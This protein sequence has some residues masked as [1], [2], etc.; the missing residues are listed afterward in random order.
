MK[1]TSSPPLSG[2]LYPLLQA[3]DEEYL[4]VD[5]QFGGID[6]RKIFT[7]AEASLPKLGFG[8][9][10]HLMNAMVP[11]LAGGKMSSSDP[12]SKIDFLDSP[13]EVKKKIKSAVAAPGVVE[14]NGLLAFIRAV[15]IPIAKLQS[16]LEKASSL[17]VTEDAPSGSLLTFV[18]KA[19][20]GGTLHFSDY[21]EIEDFYAAEKLHP[22]DLKVFIVESINALLAPVQEEFRTNPAFQEAERLAYPPPPAPEK[23]KKI[24]KTP[25]RSGDKEAGTAAVGNAPDAEAEVD[26]VV[27]GQSQSQGQKMDNGIDLA[28]VKAT[29][30]EP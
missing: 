9:R 18:R 21:Q 4:G 3:L 19:E 25:I 10:A 7:L 23:K 28:T 29:L 15:I 6:Q 30:P 1:Q 17:F 14:D 22:G 27:Q 24:A 26:G 16:G 2:L 11:G 8:K 5:I 20:H 12:Q 13:A